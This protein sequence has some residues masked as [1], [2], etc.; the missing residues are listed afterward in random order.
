MRAEL[1]RYT[2][3]FPKGGRQSMFPHT[4]GATGGRP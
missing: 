4:S 3:A 2:K 1:Y